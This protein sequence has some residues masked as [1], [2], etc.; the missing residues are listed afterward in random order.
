MDFRCSNG[1]RRFCPGAISCPGSDQLSVEGSPNSIREAKNNLKNSRKKQRKCEN[2]PLQLIQAPTVTTPLPY[3]FNQ[4]FNLMNHDLWYLPLNLSKKCKMGRNLNVLLVN[5]L[6]LR[7]LL[8]LQNTTNKISKAG[9]F[10]KLLGLARSQIIVTR[11][12]VSLSCATTP[13]TSRFA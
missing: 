5:H 12:S 3:I 4:K 7:C 1:L 10:E 11:G 8:L 9:S 13:H 2:H 6:W